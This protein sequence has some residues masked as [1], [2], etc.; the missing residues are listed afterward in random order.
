[1]FWN[2]RGLGKPYRRSLVRKHVCTDNL[3]VVALQETIKQNFEDWEIKELAGNQV[4]AWLWSP[5]KG[6]S[7]GMMIGVNLEKLEVE[8]CIYENFFMGV[9]IRNRITNYRF[10]VINVY[11]PAQHNLSKDF[12]P[13]LSS[14]DNLRLPMMMGGDFN[15]IRNNKERNHGAGDPRLMEL[16]N[17]FIG[18]FQLR[19]IFCS[20]NKFT[21]SNKQRNPTL[22][23][24]DRILVTTSWE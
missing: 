10:W 20:G 23:K 12:L 19:E 14:C 2:V 11:G 9:L 8:D 24:L 6:H 1:M 7:G 22:I 16:F 21:W 15:L 4:F 3:E 13:D 5:S 17:D 18:R